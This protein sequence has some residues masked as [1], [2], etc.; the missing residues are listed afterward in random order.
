MLRAHADAETVE[1]FL[2][3]CEQQAHDLLRPHAPIIIAL[4]I[5]LKIRRTLT[6]AEIVDVI[7]TTV[8]GLRTAAERQRRAEWRN[9]ELAAGRFRAE[10]D[11]LNALRLPSSAQDRVQ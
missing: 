4:S 11:R 5:V 6:S 3:F 10:C 1:H 2:A 9:A 7:A 8:A